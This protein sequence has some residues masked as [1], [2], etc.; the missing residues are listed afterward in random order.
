MKKTRFLIALLVM[1]VAASGYAQDS[2]REAVKQ[3][4]TAI[5]QFEKS[6]SLISDLSI[7]FER[8][9]QLDID[10]LAKRYLDEQYEN[11]MV[12]WF[13]S[14]AMVRDM[15]ETDLKEVA[16]LMS[17]PE[18]KIFE[19][20]QQDW[21]G[22]F[23]VNWMTPFM[24]MGEK[25]D[26][27]D[28]EVIDDDEEIVIEDD[29]DW[30]SGG[31][32]DLLGPPIEP[33]AEIDAAY[34]A[35]FNDVIMESAMGKSMMDA[36]MQKFN[37]D[38]PDDPK[39]QESNKAMQDW[40]LTSFPAVLL[41]SAYG[42]LTLEDLDYATKLFSNESYCKL[43]SYGSTADLENQKVGHFMVKFMD[44][45]KEQGAKVTEDPAVAA[46]FWQA[47]LGKMG[48]AAP[49]LGNDNYNDESEKPWY[50]LNLEDLESE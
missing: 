37:E 22:N 11:D 16:S 46:K 4:L 14:I 25:M 24:S 40:M 8:D 50:D 30:S 31:L 6:K 20:H 1:L 42:N 17:S 26:F 48:V 10:Q 3:Y 19:L 7:L 41:N 38:V 15:T 18:G 21:M 32:M 47:L 29:E 44:W 45:M 23:L 43:S 12:D 28:D 39:E 35:K 27:D 33:K 49:S 2:Y 9:G 5:D 34:A 13:T 36:M